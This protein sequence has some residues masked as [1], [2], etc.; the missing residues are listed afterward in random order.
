MIKYRTSGWS[1]PEAKIKTVRISR[2]TD[3]SIW[4]NGDR[5]AKISEWYQFWDTWQE[6][7]NYIVERSEELV[8]SGRLI[9]DRRKGLLGNI[10]GMKEEK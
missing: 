6:A 9:L 10:K 7:H 2:E 3:K 5:F 1:E 8:R 4:I